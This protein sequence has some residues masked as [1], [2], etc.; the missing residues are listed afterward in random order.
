[1]QAFIV[2]TRATGTY[3][4]IPD[5]AREHN[6]TVRYKSAENIPLIRL[7]LLSQT[8]RDETVIR[9]DRQASTGFDNEL[10]AGK[11]FGPK[12]RNPEIFSVMEGENYS[13]NAIPWPG[14]LTT[15]PLS[16]K[17]PSE[18]TYTI[19][20]SQMQGL[21]SSKVT[22]TDKLSGKTI[23]L[24]AL[25]EYSFAASAGTIADRFFININT[26]APELKKAEN[27]SSSLKVYASGN[28]VCILPEGSEWNDVA[29]KV[30][31][32]DIT[33]RVVM[34]V[35]NELF[36]AGEIKEYYP[37]NVSGLLIVEVNA[38]NKRYLEKI[39][40]AR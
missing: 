20:R 32:F 5:N 31:I 2:K 18:G 34:A 17:I 33:G 36:N 8:G 35:N 6:S 23:D 11:M 15:I 24:V 25:S 30:R 26:A 27:I 7:E 29:G 28:R 38:G 22:L 16:M 3:I 19:K 1:L 4:T 37:A 9:L 13:I 10:D 14:S 21:G 12:G 39:V 40:I